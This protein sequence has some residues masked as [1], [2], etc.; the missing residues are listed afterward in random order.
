MKSKTE[1]IEC[2]SSRRM[3]QIVIKNNWSAMLINF[4][5]T[6]YIVSNV[7]RLLVHGFY[8]SVVSTDYYEIYQ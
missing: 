4:S 2:L 5:S 7:I 6:K 1:A 8:S 3:I